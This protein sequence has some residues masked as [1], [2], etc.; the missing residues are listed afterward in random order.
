MST[1]SMS[2]FASISA[3]P[4]RSASCSP[5]FAAR[6]AGCRRRPRLRAGNRL[7]DLQM[8]A[9]AAAP[10]KPIRRLPS[11]DILPTPLCSALLPGCLLPVRGF[12]RR[13]PACHN[14][15]VNLVGSTTEEL[16]ALACECGQPAYRGRQ[17]AE[18]LTANRPLL[19]R[20]DVTARRLPAT[21]AERA[22][23]PLW[24]EVRRSVSTDGTA[25]V[26]T[27]AASGA[28]V[29]C[30]FLPYSERSSVCVSTQ[31]GCAMDCAFCATA[32]GGLSRSL[33]A[34][35]IVDQ[36]LLIRAALGAAVTH[37][38]Y[39]GMGEPLANY[40]PST[41]FACSPKGLPRPS[42]HGGNPD[43]IRQLAGRAACDARSVSPRPNDALRRELC[44]S[45]ARIAGLT[46]SRLPP[47]DATRRR[48]TFGICW[49]ESTTAPITPESLPGA[50][51]ATWQMSTSSPT[52]TGRQAF[53]PAAPSLEAFKRNRAPA[54]LVTE[55]LRRAARERNL[56]ATPE[57]VRREEA[58]GRLLK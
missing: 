11:S 51:T 21:L 34:G 48:M 53:S 27:E 42:E 39:M 33:R 3:R 56:R 13:G 2:A 26:L 9:D 57:R 4:V 36:V 6:R 18:W 29:E 46:A 1:A 54:S 7:P 24:K 12:L 35:E 5:A 47:L 41:A 15:R 43:A 10:N 23:H 22:V 32:M 58:G 25:K 44:R 55:R 49:T 8:I 45:P 28:R 20:D 38:V 16:V 30:V 50:S 37:V 14:V 52:T 40:R 31:V 17:L 19:Q